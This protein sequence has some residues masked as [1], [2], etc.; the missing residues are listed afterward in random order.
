MH[1]SMAKQHDQ[2]RKRAK[3]RLPVYQLSKQNIENTKTKYNTKGDKNAMLRPFS[4]LYKIYGSADLHSLNHFF[5]IRI[6]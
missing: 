5:Q 2:R 3:L 1:N 4:L 6:G